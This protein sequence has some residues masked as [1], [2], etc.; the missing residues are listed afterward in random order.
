MLTSFTQVEVL[1]LVLC[2]KRWSTDSTSVVKGRKYGFWNVKEASEGHFYWP[3]LCKANWTSYWYKVLNLKVES[4]GFVWKIAD[5]WVSF[6]RCQIPTFWVCKAPRAE[7][8]WESKRMKRESRQ[9]AAGSL[10]IRDTNTP[11]LLIPASLS[12]CFH[13][14]MSAVQD[15]HL[16]IYEGTDIWGK[17]QG[18]KVVRIINTDTWKI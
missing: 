11:F 9:R 16:C 12:V 6:P 3:F 14:A 1:I 17:M 10:L 15:M 5:C 7:T 13:H 4:V 8:K 18:V 2:I